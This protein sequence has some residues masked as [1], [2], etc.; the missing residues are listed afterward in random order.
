MTRKLVAILLVVSMF[1]CLFTGCTSIKTTSEVTHTEVSGFDITVVET[2]IKREASTTVEDVPIKCEHIFDTDEYWLYLNEEP[3]RLSVVTYDDHIEVFMA[4][5]VI[6]NYEEEVIGQF[7][8]TVSL[9]T[10]AF[11]AAAKAIIAATIAS[12]T[13]AT[14]CVS[15]D[16]IGNVIGG[17][18][19]NTSTYYRYRTFDLTAADAIRLGKMR[20]YNTYYSAYLSGNTVMIGQEISQWTAVWRLKHGYD[21]F[22]TSDYAAFSATYQAAVWTGVGGIIKHTYETR[23]GYYPH[24]HPVGRK[25]V[26][27]PSTYPHC[28]YPFT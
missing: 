24:Y 16:A 28:W 25:W 21:V 14:I 19:T 27:N 9:A 12:A 20:R 15:A 26:N 8:L 17:I 4:D 1:C 2:D 18:R 5:E 23:D 11:I 7:V 6:T 3:V 10:P 13:A 22:A